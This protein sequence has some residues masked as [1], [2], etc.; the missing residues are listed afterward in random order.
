M[1]RIEIGFEDI[2]G[3]IRK[4]KKGM[5]IIF[6]GIVLAG[7]L[8]GYIDIQLYK[9]EVYTPEDTIVQK[10]D[11]KHLN[12]DEAYYYLAYMELKEKSC[13]LNTYIQYLKQVYLSAESLKKVSDLEIQSVEEQK[14]FKEIVEFCI[15]E[16]PIICDDMDAAK[17]FVR[18]RIEIS[19]L[20][21]DKEK[22]Y[23]EQEI[24]VWKGYLS[25][26]E[27]LDSSEIK[28]T[29]SE[30]DR[31]LEIDQNSIN[32]LVERFNELVRE[33]E[34]KEQYEAVYNPYLLKKY[35][36]T[37]GVAGWYDKERMLNDRQER[38]LVYFRS[39]AGV[40]S[41]EERF[42]AILTFSIMLGVTFSLLYGG[43]ILI[44]EGK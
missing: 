10:V 27:N 6:F 35:C 34:T 28:K 24:K 7:I 2:V 9:Q 23:A 43:L 15:S 5:F 38:A 29:N 32:G 12:R 17:Q 18:Q 13:A 20:Q 21:L 4:N 41:R 30:M 37:A 36:D 44:K 3:N 39:I 26:L 31:L 8:C 33:I 42:Y 16:K 19:E 1:K 14:Q 11:L 22:P 40:D 25:K